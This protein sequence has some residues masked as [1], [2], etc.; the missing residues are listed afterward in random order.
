MLNYYQKSSI[1]YFIF[2]SI[3]LTN[4]ILL[5]IEKINILNFIY[6]LDFINNLIIF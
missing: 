4:H 1:F 6:N 3:K 2:L 5:I